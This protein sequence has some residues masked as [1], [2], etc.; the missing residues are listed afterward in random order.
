MKSN[1]NKVKPVFIVIAGIV[2]V[3]AL[4]G[5]YR[6]LT[7][8]EEEQLFGFKK[9]A[10]TTAPTSSGFCKY[11]GFPLRIGSCGND[12]KDLQRLLNRIMLPPKTQLKVDGKF[13][14]KTAAASKRELGSSSVSSALFYQ[15]RMTKALDLS[16]TSKT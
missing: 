1:Q 2:T 13:G 11:K 14:K 9:T 3:A 8:E 5:L 15:T 6:V 7:K 16:F 4:Y 10:K 12:V